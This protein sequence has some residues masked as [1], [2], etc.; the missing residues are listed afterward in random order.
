MERIAKLIDIMIDME[1]KNQKN[2]IVTITDMD[3]SKIFSNLK[4]KIQPLEDNLEFKVDLKTIFF[5]YRDMYVNISYK[6]KSFNYG[7]DIY[8]Y[9]ILIKETN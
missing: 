1:L 9:Q 6:R 5:K 2:E 3:I 4:E 8:R 7:A